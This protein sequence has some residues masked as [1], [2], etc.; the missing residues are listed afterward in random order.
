MPQAT[1]AAAL[2]YAAEQL[3]IEATRVHDLPTVPEGDD[4]R[5]VKGSLSEVATIFDRVILSYGEHVKENTWAFGNLTY[6]TSQVTDA[7]DGNALYEI[8]NA[9]DKADEDAAEAA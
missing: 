2:L 3:K 1:L 5:A 4:F 8:E 9:A 6:F 7:L